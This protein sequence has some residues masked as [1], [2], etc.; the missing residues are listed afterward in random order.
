[1]ERVSLNAAALEDGIFGIRGGFP[2]NGFCAKDSG[3]TI[4]ISPGQICL[5]KYI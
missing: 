5:R 1:M 3:L 4:G 2:T